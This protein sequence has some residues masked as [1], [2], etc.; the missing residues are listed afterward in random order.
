MSEDTR[1]RTNGGYDEEHRDDET[2]EEQ[3][4][5]EWHFWLLATLGL[6]GIALLLFPLETWPWLGT[7]LVSIAVFG[8]IFKTII[9]K[10]ME[11]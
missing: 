6:G 8:W 1:S 2:D 11:R 5:S 3:V 4:E 10:S 9:E 7:L